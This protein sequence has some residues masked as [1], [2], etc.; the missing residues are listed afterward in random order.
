MNTAN[1]PNPIWD[2]RHHG[3]DILTLTDLEWEF[4]IRLSAEDA[5][6]LAALFSR[7][8][9]H[10]RVHVEKMAKAATL[11]FWPRVVWRLLRLLA[12]FSRWVGSEKAAGFME[13]YY[14]KYNHKSIADCGST[15]VF[16]VGVSILAAKAIEDTPMFSGQETSTRYV[17]FDTA[18]VWEPTGNPAARD[19]IAR[20]MEFYRSS[21]E[22]TRGHVAATFPIKEGEKQEDW[23]NS[24]RARTFDVLRSFLPAGLTTQVAWHGNLRQIADHLIDL[25]HH[26]LEE[27]RLHANAAWMCLRRH[28]PGSFPENAAMLDVS[29]E[30][31]AKLVP[32]V[33]QFRE[34]MAQCRWAH[35]AA[36]HE[37]VF[38][39]ESQIDLEL[40][41]DRER[42]H[43][44]KRPRGAGI[45][46][47]VGVCGL[48]TIRAHV[49]YG[50]W[51]D[52]H[53]Q[54]RGAWRTPVLTPNYGFESWYLDSLP[55]DLFVRAQA[56]IGGIRRFWSKLM[57]DEGLPHAQYFL[58]MG[59]I[60][61]WFYVC[62]LPQVVYMAELRAAKTVHPTARAVAQKLAAAVRAE[63]GDRLALHADTD[64]DNW[65]VR[66][67]SQSIKE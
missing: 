1:P 45:P 37:P 35:F 32:A 2:L 51:R 38:S 47:Y 33:E 15:T 6:M 42:E 56:H 30:R 27:V 5:A 61:P 9:S 17:P 19:T 25:R 23:C 41:S 4:G 58:P 48:A 50:S 16:F 60:V 44:R 31:G 20:L 7:D 28:Y 39:F 3:A 59:F 46:S 54:R 29:G 22:P 26:P 66:R 36:M 53:R 57:L 52:L 18:P 55:G 10:P 49:D 40:L 12:V 13:R 67:G 21:Y 34:E 64:P 11:K 62:G 24:V 65:T 14:A 63:W 8:P 43:L